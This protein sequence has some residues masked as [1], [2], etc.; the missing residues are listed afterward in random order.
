MRKYIACGSESRMKELQEKLLD[1]HGYELEVIDIED[2]DDDVSDG[3]RRLFH[4]G[5]QRFR[6]KQGFG[7]NPPGF[8]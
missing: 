6:L 8:L 1:D 2:L 3:V 5:S 4:G 7:R